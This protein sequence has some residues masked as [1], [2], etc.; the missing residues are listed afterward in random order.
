VRLELR[1]DAAGAAELWA[2][3]EPRVPERRLMCSWAWVA[4]WLEH[5]GD[6]LPHRVAIGWD[7]DRV[8]GLALVAEETRRRGPVRLRVLHVGATGEPANETVYGCYN[9]LLAA[10][11]DRPAFARV[12]V[13]ALRA[14]RRWDEIALDRL[15]PDAAE[16]LLAALEGAV[17]SAKQAPTTDLAAARAS[18]GDV[19]A[20]LRSR[21]RQQ[22]RRGLRELGDVS[23]EVAEN[24]AAAEE[25]LAE[26]VELHQRRWVEAGERGAFASPRVGGF[27]RALAGR[28]VPQGEAML[29]RVRCE[30]GTVGCVYNLI[31][32]RRALSYLQGFMPA[33]APKVKPGF[34]T[35]ALCM[36]ACLDRG[37]DA[38]DLLPEPAGWKRELTTTM[39]SV[40]SA[41]LGRRGP[42]GL[43]VGAG[44]RARRSLRDDVGT[45]A[46]GAS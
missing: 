39:S 27:Y 29:V 42:K 17:T 23:V 41:R 1:R 7:G 25:V 30:A 15:A 13:R 37:L 45:P 22:V 28:L 24:V 34:V 14:E 6:L 33:P 9:G 35:H 44:R 11:A 31:E 43:L 4:T 16:P 3:L 36:Q 20:T 40:L 32:G 5:Y 12:L 8:A 46:R 38:Y 2:A 19:L 21:T 18:G 26:L 10:P